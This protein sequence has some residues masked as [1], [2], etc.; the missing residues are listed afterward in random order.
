M[1]W[2]VDVEYL[3]NQMTRE[4]MWLPWV[5]GHKVEEKG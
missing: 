5:I 2:R 4:Q 1:D 3:R